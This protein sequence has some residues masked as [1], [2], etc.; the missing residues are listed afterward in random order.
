MIDVLLSL[1]GVAG[2]VGT[3]SSALMYDHDYMTIEGVTADGKKFHISL[4]VREE[5]END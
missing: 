5:E 3:V 1:I 2:K 4:R